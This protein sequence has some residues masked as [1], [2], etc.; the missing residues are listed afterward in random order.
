MNVEAGQL[1]IYDPGYKR[2]LGK[3]KRLNPRKEGTAFVWYSAGDTAACTGINHLYP[4][5]ERYARENACD[6]DNVYAL[7]EIINK[8]E[9]KR[10]CQTTDLF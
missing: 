1:V 3:V 4:I 10:T 5:D 7:E 9:E 6:F 8:Q 2:E